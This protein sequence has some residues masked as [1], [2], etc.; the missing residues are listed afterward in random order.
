MSGCPA[1]ALALAHAMKTAT[2]PARVTEKR[3]SAR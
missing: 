1:C 3:Q 2:R